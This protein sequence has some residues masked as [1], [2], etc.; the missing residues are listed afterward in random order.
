MPAYISEHLLLLSITLFVAQNALAQVDWSSLNTDHLTPSS[1]DVAPDQ[2]DSCSS[3]V[4]SFEKGLEKT[5][6]G[7]HEGGDTSWEEKHL[8]S[9][10]D[11]EVR[12]VEIQEALCNEL[13][14]GKAQCLSMAEDGES[15]IEEWW[16]KHKNKHVKLHDFLCISR[17]KKCCP[18]GSFGLNC[19][20]CPDCGEHGQ[21]DGSGM[22]SGSG[23]CNCNQGYIGELCD[24]CD[25]EHYSSR[26]N[27]EGRFE[28]LK[29]HQACRGGCKGP[30]SSNCTECAAG[31]TRDAQTNLC[32]DINECELNGPNGMQLEAKGLCPDGTYCV[33]TDGHYQCSDC[34]HACQTCLGFGPDKC[35]TCASSYIMDENHTCLHFSA[36]EA[37]Q[38]EFWSLFLMILVPTLVMHSLATYLVSMVVRFTGINR[39]EDFYT[40]VMLRS[41]LTLSFTLWIF[42][43][44]YQIMGRLIIRIHRSLVY[45]FKGVLDYGP[46]GADG[47]EGA[48]DLS[49]ATLASDSYLNEH[50]GPYLNNEL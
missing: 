26:M 37:T 2:C 41:L 42:Y 39:L 10:A 34:H 18:E 4:K 32:I 9:Y 45:Y 16:F 20:K 7:K 27:N 28:C 11:S 1:N 49:D 29:C 47:D 17:L 6:R 36:E 44:D 23:K 14:S 19:Q 12:L 38:F 3:L 21:C 8:K 25:E 33:N 24:D 30:T 50:A 46:D 15:D 13:S 22:R 5:K 40:Q 43:L 31:Y 35:F 48:S